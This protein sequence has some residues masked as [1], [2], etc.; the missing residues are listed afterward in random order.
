MIT[1]NGYY[2]VRSGKHWGVAL[3]E[4]GVEYNHWYIPGNDDSFK[5]EYWDEI[6]PQRIIMPNETGGKSCDS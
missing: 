2:R 6:D 3:M 1:E 5:D 4:Q